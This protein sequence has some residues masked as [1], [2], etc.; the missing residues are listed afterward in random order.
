MIEPLPAWKE[1]PYVADKLPQHIPMHEYALLCKLVHLSTTL[2][3]ASPLR[4][5]HSK[6]LAL[7]AEWCLRAASLAQALL[8]LFFVFAEAAVQ[9]QPAQ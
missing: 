5:P 1:K 8:P 7:P 4:F 3:A 9:S 2:P 6:R